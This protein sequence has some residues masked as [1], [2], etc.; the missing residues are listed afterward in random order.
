MASVSLKDFE[1]QLFTGLV[2][3]N[4][5]KRRTGFGF[6][7]SVV[8]HVA[9]GALIILVPL[10][11][12][13]MP[14]LSDP[15]RVLIYSP[16]AAPPPPLPKGVAGDLRKMEPA[17][18]TTPDPKPEKPKFEAPV[19][20]PQEQPLKPEA[21]LQD[22]LQIGSETGSD[23]GVPEG[24]EEGVE[25]GLVGGIPGGILGGCVGCD[26][27]GPV[28]DWDQPPRLLRQ[29]RPVYPQEAFVKKIEGT[30]LLEILIDGTGRVI[31]TRLLRSVF[32]A[33]DHAAA[34]TVVQW[35]FSPALR[36]GRP[37][38]VWAQAPVQ[39]KIY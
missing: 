20:T 23:M 31:K 2:V 11:T 33:L 14:E 24:M 19:E 34:Q 26:G 6:P 32:P 30:V 8:A 38:A 12:S 18:P 28:I 25:G 37:V 15:L 36:R 39:F 4:P 35:S 22:S 16:P 29:T 21:R 10:L 17:K 5:P 13:D 27:D 7:A 9:I 1:D 3:S